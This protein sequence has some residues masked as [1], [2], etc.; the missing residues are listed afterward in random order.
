MTYVNYEAA[1]SPRLNK[2]AREVLFTFCPFPKE[3]REKMADNPQ[4]RDLIKKYDT[5]QQGKLRPLAGL[6]NKLKKENIE[7]PEELIKQYQV[8]QA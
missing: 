4:Y 7:V 1:E 5:Q 8:L 2:V 3:M 6:I